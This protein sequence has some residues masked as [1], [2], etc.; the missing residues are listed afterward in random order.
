MGK[1]D[2]IP[3]LHDGICRLTLRQSKTSCLFEHSP[4]IVTM[5]MDIDAQVWHLR[6]SAFNRAI[7]RRNATLKRTPVHYDKYGGFHKWGIPRMVGL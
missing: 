7:L 3:Q 2:F 1:H 4:F 6:R 5:G